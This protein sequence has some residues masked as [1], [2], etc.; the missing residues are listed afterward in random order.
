[1]Y[2][3]G[4]PPLPAFELA[5]FSR[6]EPAHYMPPSRNLHF[7]N[8]LRGDL[9][10][11]DDR[12]KKAWK[13]F[14][15]DPH[16]I[17]S[18]RLAAVGSVINLRE[19]LRTL[20]LESAAAIEAGSALDWTHFNC[21]ACH[22][23]LRYPSQR[24][25]TGYLGKPGRL[26][27]RMW[28]VIATRAVLEHAKSLKENEI[29]TTNVPALAELA[30]KYEGLVENLLKAFDK[31]QYGSP[32]DV[33][34]A[35]D[36]LEGWCSRFV[37]LLDH[38]GVYNPES[39]KTLTNMLQTFTAPEKQKIRSR[40]PFNDYDTAQHLFWAWSTVSGE[41]SVPEAERKDLK[42]MTNSEG[43]ANIARMSPL[44]W[45]ELPAEVSAFAPMLDIRARWQ[46]LSSFLKMPSV[47][48]ANTD[49]TLEK[50]APKS[51][52]ELSIERSRR[53][54]AFDSAKFTREFGGLSLK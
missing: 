45:K 10:G 25:S 52:Q 36:E 37:A 50:P 15:Y 48:L 49:E 26:F 4:H 11:Q 3:A 43:E 34:A 5:T 18:A 27:P 17:H 7:A 14:H 54:A 42:R 1:M 47:N 33:R 22:H 13:L 23:D 38:P 19:Y 44:E 21:S 51:I 35:A 31:Q 46:T 39:A 9:A 40:V 30:G 41:L 12:E 24:Q 16:E 53:R 32:K 8:I 28:S 20:S 29:G 6:D 2:A